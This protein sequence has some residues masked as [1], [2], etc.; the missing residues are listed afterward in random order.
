MI[1]SLINETVRQDAGRAQV[2]YFADHGKRSLVFAAPERSDVRSLAGARLE[3]V[4]KECAKLGL[5]SPFVQVI[6]S[7]REGAQEAIAKI[8][9][10]RTPPLAICCYNDEVAFAVMAALSDAGISIPESVA[11]IGCDDIP[12]AQLSIPSL[13]TIAFNRRQF[14]D[15]L[16]ENI[17][18]ISKGESPRKIPSI[19]LS[20]VVRGSA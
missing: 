20:V 4:R 9:G 12:L 6:P 5:K 8:L 10:K 18:L 15:L 19:P 1:L 11:V 14:L 2:A 7:S 17:V 13:T 16:I 3:G